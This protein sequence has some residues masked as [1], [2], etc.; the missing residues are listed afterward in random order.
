MYLS[1]VY[2]KDYGDE[3]TQLPDLDLDKI[4][5]DLNEQDQGGFFHLGVSL[6]LDL[7]VH[8]ENGLDQGGLI[9]CRCRHDDNN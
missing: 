5:A 1:L 2:D 3:H 8:F 6:N 9:Y 4:K 7:E